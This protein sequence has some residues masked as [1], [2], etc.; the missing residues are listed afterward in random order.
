MHVWF[1]WKHHRPNA[2]SLSSSE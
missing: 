2:I 1:T